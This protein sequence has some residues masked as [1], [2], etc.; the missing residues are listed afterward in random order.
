MRKL[1][2]FAL[3]LSLIACGMVSILLLP[4][5]TESRSRAVSITALGPTTIY[6][7]ETTLGTGGGGSSNAIRL[8][9]DPVT[10]KIVVGVFENGDATVYVAEGVT[11]P[12]GSHS[13]PQADVYDDGTGALYAP[14]SSITVDIEAMD[15]AEA[16]FR[17]TYSAGSKADYVAPKIEELDLQHRYGVCS[18]PNGTGACDQ[19]NNNREWWRCF[20]CCFYGGGCGA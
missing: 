9:Y 18:N 6:D 1:N 5:K 16:T 19:V 20:V 8:S 12:I 4:N 13:L 15:T 14:V 10:E 17:V 7:Y 3:A 11:D 2:A